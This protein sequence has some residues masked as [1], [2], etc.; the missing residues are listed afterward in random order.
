MI[1]VILTAAVSSV[2]TS[3]AVSTIVFAAIPDGNN[4][5][6]GCYSSANG[7]LR[8]I[9]NASASC[10]ANEISLLWARSGLTGYE[11]AKETK[12]AQPGAFT[13]ANARCSRGKSVLGGG[14][15]G[16]KEVNQNFP[17]GTGSSAPS[18]QVAVTN[19]TT[20]S[21]TFTAY[22]ICARLIP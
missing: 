10:N 9:D 12:E 7:D 1:L 22:A 16:A 5:I 15:H 2:L 14:F 19:S 3:L 18:W 4:V 21:Y 20:G 17:Q 8:V 11:V 6:H 13:V